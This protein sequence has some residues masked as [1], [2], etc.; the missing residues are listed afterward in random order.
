MEGAIFI[1]KLECA[2]QID[3]DSLLTLLDE[4]IQSSAISASLEDKSNFTINGVRCAVRVY[5]R[6]SLIGSNR[7]SLNLTLLSAGAAVFLSAITSGG[8]QAML[9][10][11]N[12]LGEGAFLEVV[13]QAVE[14]YCV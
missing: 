8:S 13:R 12:T 3:F 4:S 11:V 7:V 5:E 1:S 6:Y 2:L 9:F 10:K 14:P